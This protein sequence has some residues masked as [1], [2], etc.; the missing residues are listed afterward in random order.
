MRV[1]QHESS[2]SLRIA[3]IDACTRRLCFNEPH[4]ILTGNIRE[5]SE[6]AFLK[7]LVIGDFTILLLLK[8]YL[9]LSPLPPL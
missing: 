9:S 6:P 3:S 2:K 5:N 4:Q 1:N 7:I 8:L